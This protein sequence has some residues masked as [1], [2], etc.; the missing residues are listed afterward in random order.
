VTALDDPPAAR[1]VRA[2]AAFLLLALVAYSPWP[3]GSANPSGQ[4]VLALG[5][6]ALV[7]LWAAHAVVTR[8]LTYR[9]DAVSACLL[10]LVLVTAFQLVPLPES[11]ARVLSPVAAEWHRTLVPAS[12][13][14][15]PGESEADVP[16][17]SEWVRLSVAPAAT[18]DLLVQFLAAFLVYAA[19]R[20][21]AA[22][23]RSLRR[24]AW[25]GFATGTGL[26]L[27]A[28][29]QY[30]S[31]ERE[32]I[33]WQVETGGPVFG[34]FVNKNHFAFQIHLFAGLA[35]G[36][37]LSVARR[38]GVSSPAGIALLG[39]LGLMVA[40]VGFSQSRGGVL[41]LV[42]GAALTG[43]VARLSRNGDSGSARE[44]RVGLVLVVGVVLIAV[45]LTAWLGWGRVVDRL[46]TF[47]QGTADDRTPVWRR[48]WPLVERFPLTGVGGGGYTVAELAT[49]TTYDGS[50]ISTTAHNE[51]L[52]AAIE[53]GVVRFALTVAL[54][55][56]AVGVAVRSYR[57]TRDP[58]LL[59]CVF[60]LG[61]VAVHSV[62]DFGLHVPSVAVAAAAVAACAARRQETGDR[63]QGT[64]DRGDDRVVATRSGALT[65]P[66]AYTAA[67]LLV[68]AG[69]LV[70]LADW[71]AYR[72]DRLRVAATLTARA[73]GAVR[74]LDAAAR[75]R[76]NDPDVWDELALAHL[77]VAEDRGQA[78]VA[79]VA[80]PAAFA[81]PP[82]V[83]PGAD[84]DGH[85]A[86]AL[87]AARA[88]RDRQPLLPGPHMQLGTFADR[89]ARTEPAPIHFDRAKRVGGI[90]PDVWYVCGKGAADRGDWPAALADWRE[91]LARSP[92]RLAAIARAAAGRILPG[93]FR[94]GALPDDPAVWF[95]ATPALFPDAA[96]PERVKW[97]RAIAD[98]WAAGPEPQTVAGF[99]AWATALEELGDAAGAIR[100]GR[101]AAERFPDDVP[102]RDRLA[103]RL[104]AE[105]LY[106]EAEPVLAWLAERRPDDGRYRDR[107]AATRH[108]LKLKRDINGP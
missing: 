106:E 23:G 86:A 95:A 47:W 77:Q 1:K 96:D 91:S 60:G 52:E 90:E 9:P 68:F 103:E 14:L 8:R 25:V 71:R 79:A 76:P 81:H 69:L 61:A 30:L 107:L 65:G 67:G 82:G 2:A 87:K 40:G 102:T 38:E 99:A 100:V 20:N 31:G 42:A 48:A 36:L 33:F 88:G 24:L 58:L 55:V 78:A 35:V 32:R 101:R 19:A 15:L 49:R 93:Q 98:R 4:V 57:R 73:E 43:A 28:L 34:T 27:L 84:P 108:A 74:Y 16:R 53:G 80:G 18:E 29:A 17:R 62:G 105:E 12:P 3:F 75:I 94:A 59:G 7:G 21:F 56:A 5:V 39:G 51:Y 6:L 89:L 13:E 41:G 70:V 63:R 54:A 11:V 10:G 104:E 37:F 83:L 45:G 72:V 26:A 66:A 92:K 64:E 50:Y 97:L 22:D 85:I 44:R 46:A